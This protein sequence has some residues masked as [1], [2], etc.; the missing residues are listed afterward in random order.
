MAVTAAGAAALLTVLALCLGSLAVAAAQGGLAGG[1]SAPDLRALRFTVL[2][3]TL[4]S[5]LSVGLAVPVTRALARR[6]FPGRDAALSLLGAPFLLPVIVAVIGVIAVWGRSGWLSE[7]SLGLGG[8]RLDVYGLP[9]VVIVHVFFNLPL[10]A[11]LMLQ[12]CAEVPAERWRVAAQLGMEGRALFAAVEWP[13]LRSAAA[14]AFALT[15][16]VCATSFAAALALGGGPRATT[17]EVAIYEAARY[18]FD[19]GRAAR[20]A[21]LQAGVCALAAGL[22]YAARAPMA[23]GAGVLRQAERFDGRGAW[24]RAGDA[25]V[26]IAA[27]AFLL[28]PIAA[29]MLRGAPSLFLLGP[30]VLAAA[31]RTAAV[32]VASAALC[33]AAALSLA[34]LVTALQTRGRRGAA[35][36][37]LAGLAPVAASPF[38]IGVGVIVALRSFAD[39][40]ALAMPLTALINAL[41]ATPFALRILTPALRLGWEEHG[42]LAASLGLTGAT[43][44]RAVYG[45]RLRGPLGFSAG[46]AAALS[47]GDLG[48]IALFATPDAP[49]LPLLM[50][51]LASSRQLDAA[52]AAALVLL[53][54]CL[55]LF[56]LFDLAGRSAR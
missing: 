19:L 49:T 43:R 1:F 9:G 31:A 39:P 44:L 38:V 5:A 55:A 42:R 22:A 6:R 3:A 45:A 35:L 37:D 56:R 54:L 29:I 13:A 46:L 30:E 16:L 14:A 2:Q 52:M 7:I 41:A 21:A 27:A 40:F 25:A 8:P 4:S 20:L 50:H 11:R 10:A 12:A 15:F 53:A 23:A 24:A 51:L 47:A 48:V 28:A 17:L 32:A 33:V 26:L 36:A 34:A 18:E